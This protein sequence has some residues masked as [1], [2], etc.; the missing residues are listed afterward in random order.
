MAVIFF[1]SIALVL[2]SMV[3]SMTELTTFYVV[4]VLPVTVM[5]IYLLWTGH[6]F[7]RACSKE[8]EKGDKL[9]SLLDR[10]EYDAERECVVILEEGDIAR[11][12]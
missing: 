6:D 7:S 4:Y 11:G 5:F 3:C 2:V 10:M 9:L 8:I 1:V 12:D